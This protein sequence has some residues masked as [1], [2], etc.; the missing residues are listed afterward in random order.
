LGAYRVAHGQPFEGLWD[1]MTARELGR[2]DAALAIQI[3]S[4][5][6]AADLPD[7]GIGFLTAALNRFPGES[8]VALGLARAH[9]ACSRTEPALRVLEASPSLAGSPEGQLLV[10]L[11]HAADGDDAR[12]RAAARKCR[13]QAAERPDLRLALGRLA[14][15]LGDTRQA[16]EDLDAAASGRPDDEETRYYAGLAYADGASADEAEGPLPQA[17]AA[18]HLKAAVQA[19]PRRARAGYHLGRLLYEKHGQWQKALEVYRRAAKIDPGFVE[20]EEGLARVCAALKLPE[21]LYH[22]ARVLE[23]TQRADEALPLYRQWGERE[24]ERWDSV[25][26]AAECW[27]DLQRNDEAAR[28][29]QRGLRRFPDHPELL[30]SLSQITLV[31]G[32]VNEVVSLYERWLRKDATSGRPEWIRGKAALKFQDIEGALRWIEAA[33]R[34]DPDVALY[35]AELAGA[36]TRQPTSERLTRARTAF[37]RAIELEPKFPTYHR[38]LATVLQQ[39]GDPE[40]A[41]AAFLRS[42]TLDSTRSEPYVGLIA[43]AQRQGRPATARLLADIERRVRDQQR[44]ETQAWEHVRRRPQDAGSR[45]SLGEALSRRGALQQASDHLEVAV[46]RAPT[47]TIAR[48]ALRRVRLLADAL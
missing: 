1:L 23:M 42:L 17:K 32:T 44:R 29:L 6:Q 47:W 28:E 11:A 12:S 33:I 18:E 2:D 4:A 30:Y 34:K 45:Y 14:L 48:T 22:E 19:A 39:L 7:A 43:L 38:Q 21:A 3:G 40:G 46:A 16:R 41:R 5:L 10:A 24:P 36:L 20:A 8:G 27:I 13:A 26:R 31:T 37:Q 35:H 15:A 25:L 9:L